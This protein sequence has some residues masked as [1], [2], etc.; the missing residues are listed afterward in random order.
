MEAYLTEVEDTF[1]VSG[2]GLII[3][4]LF[5]ISEYKLETNETLR[6][7]CPDGRGFE[8]E[9]Y[10]QIPFQTPPAKVLAMNCALIKVE[11]SSVPIGSKI[12]VVGKSD[13]DIRQ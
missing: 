12:W 3:A 6:V 13:D 8:C 10:F 11:K 1:S 4:P 5:P 9:G 7:E 2:R